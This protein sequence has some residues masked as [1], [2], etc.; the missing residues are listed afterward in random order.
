M[1]PLL[2]LHAE[3]LHFYECLL[4][5]DPPYE[6]VWLLQVPSSGSRDFV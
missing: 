5:I 3:A 2:S 4:Q 1:C 6:L